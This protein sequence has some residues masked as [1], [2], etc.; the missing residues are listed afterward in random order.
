M[1]NKPFLSLF[2]IDGT[3]TLSYL[4]SNRLELLLEITT[5]P[6]GKWNKEP[7]TVFISAEGEFF[8]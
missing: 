6:C 7:Y 8:N 2:Q 3:K 1:L 4:C 5:F